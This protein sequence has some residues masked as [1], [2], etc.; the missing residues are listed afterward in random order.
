MPLKCL[1]QKKKDTL[2]NKHRMIQVLIVQGEWIG[3]KRGKNRE[4]TE[5]HTS[6]FP[7]LPLHPW[8]VNHRRHFL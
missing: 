6:P 4:V 1:R 2:A 5:N 8:D 7:V 3:K